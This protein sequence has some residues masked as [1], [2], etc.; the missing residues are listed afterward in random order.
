MIDN[1]ENASNMEIDQSQTNYANKSSI[2]D[3][4]TINHSSTNDSAHVDDNNDSASGSDSVSKKSRDTA[5]TT[6]N[7][8]LP[9]V[10]SNLNIKLFYLIFYAWN[11]I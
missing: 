8:V 2:R 9:C 4:P 7:D 6:S 11:D 5:A 3:K 10:Q 1:T